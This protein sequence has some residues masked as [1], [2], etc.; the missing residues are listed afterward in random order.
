MQNSVIAS[1]EHWFSS[2]D[3]SATFR[4]LPLFIFWCIWITRN[5]C[6]FENVK[7]SLHSLISRVE[8]L[9]NLYL[10]KQRV[11]KFRAIGPKPL[12]KFPCA[13]FDGAATNNLGGAGFVV[14]LNE[15]HLFSFSMGCGCST[16]T[17]AELLALWAVLRVSLI[18]GLPLL[19]IY[20]DSFVII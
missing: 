8:S 15:N 18:M 19:M 20:G 5:L 4:Q 3:R 16:N 9:L 7:P 11:Q 13:F 17:R 14:Y 10:V 1:L 2:V 12:K 6:H